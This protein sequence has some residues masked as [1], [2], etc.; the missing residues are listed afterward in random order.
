M[1]PENPKVFVSHASEDKERFVLGFAESLYSK[2]VEAWV[3]R[4]E[5]LPGDSLVQKIFEEGIKN[6]QAMIV[7]ISEY[8]INKRW[9]QAE[10]NAGVVNHIE[11]TSRLIPVV[12]GNVEKSQ[13][14]QSLTDFLWEPIRDLSNYDAELERIVRSIYGQLQKPHLGDPPAYT[15]ME[16]DTIPGLDDVDSHILRLCCEAAIEENMPRIVIDPAALVEVTES[17][18]IPREHTLESVDILDNRGYVR[19]RRTIS[20][21]IHSF[22]L[23]DYGFGEYARTDLPD[24]NEL[25]RS[26]A[27]QIVNHNRQNADDIA[28]S[29]VAPRW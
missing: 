11:Q 13:M 16:I 23:T 28:E 3:D 6:A 7:V 2:G 25:F 15:H 26:V 24:Y 17:L 21:V 9:V 20:G 12:I 10:L 1:Q 18:D 29:L 22:S 14:P 27:L 8:S 19:A 5:M 4:W